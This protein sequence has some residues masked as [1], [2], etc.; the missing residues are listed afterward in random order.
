MAK[1]FSKL[2]RSRMRKLASRQSITE[3]GITFERKSN[4]D[5]VFSINIMVD[6]QRIHRVVGHESDGTTRKQVED[7][8][9]QIR[10][11]AKH[12]RLNLPKR[13]K[14]LR[15]FREAAT[16]YIWKLRKSGGNEIDRKEKRLTLHLIPFFG[17]KPLSQITDFDV[18]RYKKKRRSQKALNGKPDA[19]RLRLKETTVKA[20]TINR[21]LAVLS[22]L[23]NSAVDWGWIDRRPCHIRKLREDSGRITYL[24]SNQ[25][26]ALLDSAREDCNTQIYAFIRIGLET[27]M[28]LSE[29]LSIRKSD[30]DFERRRIHIPKAKAGQRDQPMTT[31]LASY[32][33][34]YC[35]S[36]PKDT[37]WIFPSSGAKTGHTNTVRKGMRRVVRA[38]GLDPDIVTPHVLRHTAITHLVQ[39]GVDLPTVK[40]IS[41]HRTLAMV[42]RYA[43]ANGEHIAFAMRK[44]ESCYEDTLDDKVS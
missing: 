6:G 4:G 24:T 37:I 8:I 28:R 12:D 3:H 5:G 27:G 30:I 11:D 36:L 21:E 34:P 31:K 10:T 33:Q 38:A 44:L 22:H 14:T 1:S 15:G 18:E 43:H 32:L 20:A 25:A 23:L 9:A 7:Y 26:K 2:T 40:R 16:E 41:G 42:E 35:D 19:K 39:S 17:S 13:R 29:I